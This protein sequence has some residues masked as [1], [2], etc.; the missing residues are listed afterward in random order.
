VAYYNTERPHKALGMRP[1]IDRFRLAAPQ[2]DPAV[3]TVLEPAL[4][5]AE[6][7]VVEPPPP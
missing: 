1:P 2:R 3:E 6:R 7:P 4:V 5:P